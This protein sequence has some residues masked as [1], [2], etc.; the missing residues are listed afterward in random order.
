MMNKCIQNKKDLG[1][2]LI[3]NMK[4]KCEE[5]IKKPDIEKVDK[6]EDEKEENPSITIEKI[7]IKQEQE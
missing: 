7:N 6:K 3:N 5:K 4:K 2:K 1:D